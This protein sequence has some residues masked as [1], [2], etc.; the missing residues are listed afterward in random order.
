M[1]DIGCMFDALVWLELFWTGKF[2]RLMLTSIAK[3][4]SRLALEQAME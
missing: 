2:L 4:I 3:E 1:H